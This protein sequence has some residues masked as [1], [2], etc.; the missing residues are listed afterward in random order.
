MRLPSVARGDSFLQRVQ[1]AIARAIIGQVP[2]PILTM[3]HRREYFGKEF[4]QCLNEAMRGPS[5]EW[6]VADR[7]IFSAFV[8][9]LNQCKY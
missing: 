7:E 2:G 6:T 8:S 1:L 3:S 5:E 9:S 4:A